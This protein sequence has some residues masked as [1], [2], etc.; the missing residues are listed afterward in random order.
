MKEFIFWTAADMQYE[1][2]EYGY[3]VWRSILK[4]TPVNT[5]VNLISP[6]IRI[7]ALHVLADSTYA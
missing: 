1:N 7:Q 2:C 4:K 3:P 6:K 5:P